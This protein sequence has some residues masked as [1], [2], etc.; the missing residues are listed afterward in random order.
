[1]QVNRVERNTTYIVSMMQFYHGAA[2]S[3]AVPPQPLSPFQLPAQPLV[4][5]E[6][7]M[8]SIEIFDDDEHTTF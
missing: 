2:S 1:M 7:P 8:D 3:L 5:P 6:Q 4:A